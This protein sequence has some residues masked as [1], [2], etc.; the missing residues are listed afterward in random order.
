LGRYG[1]DGAVLQIVLAEFSSAVIDAVTE[2]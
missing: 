2:L 1:I